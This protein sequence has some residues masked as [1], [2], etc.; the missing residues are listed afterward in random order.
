MIESYK[1]LLKDLEIK[2]YE[3]TGVRE[4][5]RSKWKGEGK[6]ESKMLKLEEI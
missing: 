4:E 5:D 2:R 1:R 6:E 3:Q